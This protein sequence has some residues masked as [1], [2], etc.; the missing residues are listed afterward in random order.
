MAVLGRRARLGMAAL[1]AAVALVAAVET[2]G[3][4][5]GAPEA[6]PQVFVWAEAARAIAER[7]R[8]AGAPAILFIG[9]SHSYLHDV[10]AQVAHLI[11]SLGRPMPVAALVAAPGIAL[12]EPA[13]DPGIVALLREGRWDWVVLQ[14]RSY[15]TLLIP[16]RAHSDAAFNKLAAAATEGGAELLVTGTWAMG[17]GGDIYRLGATNSFRGPANPAQMTAM[18]STA[19]RATAER[20]GATFVPVGEVWAAIEAAQPG[21][22]LRHPDLIHSAPA[23]AYLSALLHAAV[24]TG[25]APTEMAWAPPTVPPQMARRIRRAA[26]DA[27]GL[28]R[29]CQAPVRGSPR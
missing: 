26:R 10:P 4:A 17:A 3:P 2:M 18:V 5:G 11:A 9:N 6:I 12:T 25:C 29:T 22:P 20:I 23:G 7:P 1:A 16:G 13:Q 14:E 15:E 24:L 19:L 8:P 27:L 21:L 28:T